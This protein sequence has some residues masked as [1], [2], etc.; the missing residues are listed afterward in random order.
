MSFI[1]DFS[2][3]YFSKLMIIIWLFGFTSGLNL[4]ITS[5]TLNFWLA[6]KQISLAMIGWFS[7]VSLP[8]SFNF[9]WAFIFDKVKIPYLSSILG[10]RRSWL[11]VIQ[12]PLVI[13]VYLLSLAIHS[14]A[15]ILI[16]AFSL[17]ISLLSSSLDIIL[18]A[19]RTDIL[20]NEDLGPGA[21]IYS[22]G[23][24][25]G[26][27]ISGSWAIFLSN[28]L[29]F[30]Q[31]Y[32]I[33]A[34]LI[35]FNAWIIFYLSKDLPTNPI[36]VTVKNLNFQQFCSSIINSFGQNFALVFIFLIL[37]RLGD[38]ILNV[39]MNPFLIDIGYNALE[40]AG[41]G[42][43]LSVIGTIIGGVIGG[44]IIYYIKIRRALI[45]FALLHALTHLLLIVQVIIG[46][47]LL[48]LVVAISFESITAGM[49]MTAFITLITRLCKGSDSAT[50]YSILSASMGISRSII[51]IMA[52]YLV[53]NMG[54]I[55]FFVSVT[56]I[57][58]PCIFLINKDLVKDD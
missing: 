27:L 3:I 18:N 57:S 55:K 41:Y 14:K 29:G 15:L 38:N 39:M 36:Q 5:Y 52:G 48:F 47:N 40:I 20:K 45:S 6:S 31:I 46:K 43:F 1:K 28:Y 37:Y 32:K 19:Y 33:I 2:K 54:W 34:F 17:I 8:Y 21:A 16:A 24:R 10:M 9:I 51:P 12:I 13:F 56:I 42:K 23:Y 4:Y 58:L 30:D 49:S 35:L 44:Y 11:I 53:E 26:M 7:L 50:K 25:I 22:F